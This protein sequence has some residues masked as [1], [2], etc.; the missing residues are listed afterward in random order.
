MSSLEPHNDFKRLSRPTPSCGTARASCNSNRTYSEA[1]NTTWYL[2]LQCHCKAVL[3]LWSSSSPVLGSLAPRKWGKLTYAWGLTHD[4]DWATPYLVETCRNSPEQPSRDEEVCFEILPFLASA[5]YIV[6]IRKC[7]GRDPCTWYYLNLSDRIDSP[8]R[9]LQT[10]SIQRLCLFRSFHGHRWVWC[11]GLRS[12]DGIDGQ[13]QSDS[14]SFGQLWLW[15]LPMRLWSSPVHDLC[16][17]QRCRA[18]FI[19]HN[20]HIWYIH[21]WKGQNLWVQPLAGRKAK[22]TIS[23]IPHKTLLPSSHFA[24]PVEAYA[25]VEGRHLRPWQTDL[26]LSGIEFW[27]GDAQP[28]WRSWQSWDSMLIRSSIVV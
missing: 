15:S 25:V 3:F 17:Q 24:L 22:S 1:Q 13:K 18:E 8:L 10:V 23:P 14:G 2:S 20:N 5:A 19:F 7:K 27:C 4:L 6:R 21:A 28:S 9:R 16:S 26:N 11:K 12:I